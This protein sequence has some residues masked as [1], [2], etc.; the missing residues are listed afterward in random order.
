MSTLDTRRP[1]TD[2]RQSQLLVENRD[3]C[4]PVR[5]SP[6]KYCH[7]TQYGK[8]RMVWRPD[9]EKKIE[10]IFTSTAYTNVTD[11][12]TN[13]QTDGR[14]DVKKQTPHNGRAYVWHRT[15]KI[16]TE[17]LSVGM[18]WCRMV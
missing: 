7:H 11:R 4:S 5:G 1:I 10:G 12:Q 3:F 13:R 9:S 15:A 18:V 16:M 17:F 8:T 6:S 14:T 2:R